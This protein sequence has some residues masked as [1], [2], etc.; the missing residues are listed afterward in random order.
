MVYSGLMIETPNNLPDD[1][2]ALKEIISSLSTEYKSKTT[3]Y[4][5][6]IHNLKNDIKLLEEEKKILLHRLFGRRSE[7]LTADDI[8]QGL[9]FDEAEVHEDRIADEDNVSELVTV[10][11]EHERKKRGRRPLPVGLPRVE[12]VHDI[13][14]AEKR[15]A[16]GCEM[17]RIGEETSEKLDI[18]PAKI[19]VIRHIRYKYACKNCEGTTEDAPAVKTAALP[20]QMVPQGIVSPGLLAWTLTGKFCD[21]LPFYR[22]EK[23][24]ARIGVEIG[25]ATFCNWAVVAHRGCGRLL[26]LMWQDILASPLVGMDETSLQVLKE[27]GKKNATKSYMWVFR[28][29]GGERPVVMFRYTPGRGSEFVNREFSGYTG[30]IMTDGYQGYDELG[31][32]EGVVHAACWAHVRRK[33]ME[34][35]KGNA[36]QSLAHAVIE[37]I[38]Q[39][40]AVE[41][42]IREQGYGPEKI[43]EL[44][45]KI[46]LP[47]VRKVEEL[48]KKQVHHIAPK[49]LTGKAI[50]YTLNLWPRLCVY[51]DNPLIPIDNNPVENAIRPFV[52]GRKNWLF[53]GSP[54]GAH[55]SAGIYSIIETAKAGGLEPYWYLR[56][57][58]ENLPACKNDEEIAKL[59]PHRIDAKIIDEFRGGVV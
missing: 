4:E 42:D 31:S 59:L 40:Y 58:F 24:F 12:V 27:P 37:F 11:R 49:S 57:L 1:V 35:L 9:L 29:G 10:V 14:D 47:V 36:D 2:E 22:Q 16:C 13:A 5:S 3:E 21:A 48:L 50:S 30:A 52:V 25:R 41:S 46:S 32:K 56:Y 8:M 51:C 44:R 15:C 54:R 39:L 38:R 45:Q 55:A 19:Q 18:I 28:G 34:A 6:K 26:E 20:P 7:K 17:T 53:S 23:L 43:H 33:F